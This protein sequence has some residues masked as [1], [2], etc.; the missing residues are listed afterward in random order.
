MVR[1]ILAKYPLAAPLI[2]YNRTASRTLSF[3]SSLSDPTKISPASSLA[4]V[5]S[6]NIILTCIADD[7]AMLSTIKEI[8]PYCTGKKLF[9]DCS[10]IHPKTTEE[11]GGLLTCGKHEGG[12]R[13]FK[14]EFVAMPVFGAP[15]A[16]DTGALVCVPAGPTS[17]VDKALPF[18]NAVG[19]SIINLGGQPYSASSTLKIIGNTFILNM[20][21]QLAE[22]HVLAET[23]GLGSANLQKFI[24]AML[25]GA[26]SAYSSRMISGDY[27]T[28]AEP[29]FA[30]DLAI[31]DASH[32]LSLGK[33]AGADTAKT[34]ANTTTGLERLKMVKEKVGEDGDMPG[35]YGV[36]R[37]DAGLRFGNQ[38]GRPE[39]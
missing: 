25:P 20:V 36:V 3:A 27:Y 4:E 21:N 19:R 33:E 35:V 11:I 17:S 22:G 24:D 12:E 31:K 14:H 9:I 32:A 23:T 30:V 2:I 29:L 39:P 26:Y 18:A 28:R 13:G 8:L 34:M 6:A 1:N 5:A 38:A 37:E 7:A 15:A 16:A 10:T